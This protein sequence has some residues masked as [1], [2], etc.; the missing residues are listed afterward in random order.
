MLINYLFGIDG[1]SFDKVLVTQ[2]G[3][4]FNID[5]RF[6]YGK[7]VKSKSFFNSKLDISLND[8]LVCFFNDEQ[9]KEMIDLCLKAFLIIRKYCFTKFIFKLIFL[10]RNS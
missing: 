10:L 7:E 1:R 6:L 5:L 4:I 8:F 2:D 3:G 9:V